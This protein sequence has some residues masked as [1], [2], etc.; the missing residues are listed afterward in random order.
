MSDPVHLNQQEIAA[1]EEEQNQHHE[2]DNCNNFTTRLVLKK[3]KSPE[4]ETNQ[5][6]EYLVPTIE[7]LP[8]ESTNLNQTSR[9]QASSPAAEMPPQTSEHAEETMTS[10]KPNANR[11]LRLLPN[12][13]SKQRLKSQDP[14]MR[15]TIVSSALNDEAAIYGQSWACGFRKLSPQQKLFAKKAIDE[16]LILGQLEALKFNT[17]SMTGH[18]METG[19]NDEG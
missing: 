7:V 13:R 18:F 5:T 6:R 19:N 9:F 10:V 1:I 14:Y 8:N 3:H 15:N 16:I 2:N 12:K 11:K 17:V 4:N